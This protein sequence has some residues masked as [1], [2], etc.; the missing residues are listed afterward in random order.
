MI[1]FIVRRVIVMIPVLLVLTLFTF[2]LVRLVPG[3]P[4]LTM[5]GPR[6]TPEGVAARAIAAP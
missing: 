2:L 6:A 3:N 5:L 4:A 1:A